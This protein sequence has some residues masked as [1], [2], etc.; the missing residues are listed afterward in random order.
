MK[1]KEAG[2]IRSGRVFGLDLMRAIAI[3]L[4]L[5]SHFANGFH[6]LGVCGVELF[7]VMSGFLIGGILLN[8]VDK[9]SGFE[10]CELK[11]FLRRRWFRTLPNYYLFLLAYVVC[12]DER[13]SA[14]KMGGVE[15]AR[16]ALFLQNFAWPD[17]P[18]YFYQ[19]WS[20]CVE[21]WFY[22]LTALTLFL[23]IKL[24][25]P[26]PRGRQWAVGITIGLFIVGSASVR[27]ALRNVFEEIRLI[28]ICR[29]D[30]IMYGVLIAVIRKRVPSV[31]SRPTILMGLGAMIATAA[32]ALYGKSPTST[33]CSLTLLPIGFAGLIPAFLMATRPQRYI[34][35]TV[36]A[37][38]IGSY[39]MYLCHVLVYTGLEPIVGYSELGWWQKLGFKVF[40]TG[41]T[42]AVSAANYR[43]FERPITDLRD[44]F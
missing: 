11:D 15:L 34:A 5:A 18:W 27:F 2:G 33:A 39:S 43:F 8:T 20:L 4:V 23:M 19:S 22:L 29:L 26:S 40:A 42:V 17:G 1:A 12:F 13:N 14:F 31:W 7:F 10:L 38:S 9:K 32:V 37:I 28:V 3:A 16:R 44:R 21:E 25:A 41:V 30:A 6:I 24:C 36:E 35:W